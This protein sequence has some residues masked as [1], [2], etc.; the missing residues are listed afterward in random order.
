LLFQAKARDKSKQGRGGERWEN[1]NGVFWTT[2]FL[3]GPAEELIGARNMV[4]TATSLFSTDKAGRL[5]KA[6]FRKSFGE[7][8]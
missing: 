8:K 3:I 4:N 5:V 6:I 2:F 7:K 1:G